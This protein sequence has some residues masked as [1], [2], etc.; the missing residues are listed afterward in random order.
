[1]SKTAAIAV[2][3]ALGAVMRYFVGLIS[4]RLLGSDYPWGTLIVN[5]IGAFLIGFLWGVFEQLEI[6]DRL[7]SFA[8]VANTLYNYDIRH[9]YGAKKEKMHKRK[10]V[11]RY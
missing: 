2:G 9:I 6:S 8:L 3:G 10:H 5:L 1:M 4:T 7:K 11:I